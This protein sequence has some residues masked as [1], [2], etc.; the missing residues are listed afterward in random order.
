MRAYRIS[1]TLL[2]TSL[3]I[4]G[5]ISAQPSSATS[6]K[7]YTATMAKPHIPAGRNGGTDD[8]HCFLIDPKVN[9]DS[10][11]I[12][13][14]FVPQNPAIVHHAILFQVDAADVPQAQKLNVNGDGWTCFG[15]SGVGGKLG[16][17]LTSPWLS[18]VSPHT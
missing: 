4:S 3:A 13:S 6:V 18:S 14:Q 7:T 9:V 15:G 5:L 10:Q 11:I 2:A 16:S 1:L 12:A 17:F 8:Y